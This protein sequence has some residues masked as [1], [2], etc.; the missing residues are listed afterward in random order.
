M[1]LLKDCKLT[2]FRIAG[3]GEATRLALSIGGVEF[4][5]ERI[6]FPAWK[7]LKP[8]TPWG[9]LPILTLSNGTTVAQQRAIL[10]FVGKETGLY[11][12]DSIAA[13]K[14]DELMDVGEDI[15]ARAFKAGQGLDQEAKE[16]ARKEAC[17]PGG[18][19]HEILSKIDK[20]VASNAASSFAVGTNLTVADLFLY[21]SCN[22]LVSGLYDGVPA[23]ALNE[24]EN[25]MNLRKAVRSHPSV[26]K[27]YDGL[28]SSVKVPSSY[29]LL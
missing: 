24:F 19:I 18:S 17:A 22:N 25:L 4:I 7:E 29:G 3:R 21:C 1:S 10:R 23:E 26:C 28:D 15:G 13:A 6:A 20:T 12:T 27:W 8:K 16:A 9:S 11:P 2:Y 14:V 5:D